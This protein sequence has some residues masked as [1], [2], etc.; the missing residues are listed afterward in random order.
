M[1]ERRTQVLVAGGSLVGLSTSVLLASHVFGQQQSGQISGV[2][3]D[4]TGAVTPGATVKA[5]EVG[6]GFVRTTV[7][8]TEGRI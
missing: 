2:V 5:I 4:S 7:A 1:R 8:G 6:T 3:T